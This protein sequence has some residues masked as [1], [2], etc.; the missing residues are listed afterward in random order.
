ML[1]NKIVG[2]GKSSLTARR[3]NIKLGTDCFEAFNEYLGIKF[4][5]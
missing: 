5:K 1:V 4:P 3:L 2:Y